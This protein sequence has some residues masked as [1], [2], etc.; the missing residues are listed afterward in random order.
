MY[1]AVVFDSSLENVLSPI[2]SKYVNMGMVGTGRSPGSNP[3]FTVGDFV[4]SPPEPDFS[5]PPSPLPLKFMRG[6]AHQTSFTELR[7]LAYASMTPAVDPKQ[8]V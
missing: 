7:M 8:R 1:V 4:L 2:N 3:H 6:S 5:L